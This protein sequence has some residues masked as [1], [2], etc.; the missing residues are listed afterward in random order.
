MRIFIAGPYTADHPREVLKNVNNAIDAGIGVMKKGHDVYIPHLSHYI[1]LRPQCPFVY[2][3][4]LQ[5]DRAFLKICDALLVIGSSPGTDREVDF[6]HANNIKIY[7]S[8]EEIDNEA[9]AGGRKNEFYN[10]KLCYGSP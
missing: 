8:I 1:H 5:N 4:Y 9:I 3:E 2:E 7:Y 6:A 10:R